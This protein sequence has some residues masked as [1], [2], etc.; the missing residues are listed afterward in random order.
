MRSYPFAAVKNSCGATS[1]TTSRSSPTPALSPSR[2]RSSTRV[3]LALA[4]ATPPETQ[5]LCLAP[6]KPNAGVVSLIHRIR[7]FLKLQMRYAVNFQPDM[8][9]Q[10]LRSQLDPGFIQEVPYEV[11]R[12]AQARMQTGTD[13][14]PG[15]L[16]PF[17]TRAQLVL[18]RK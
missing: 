3:A 16:A 13:L 6:P 4:L 7:L 14:P 8:L 2:P 17:S 15:L 10:E 18:L 12:F 9:P 11:R 1:L 5:N